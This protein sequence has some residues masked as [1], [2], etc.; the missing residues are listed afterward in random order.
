V[1]GVRLVVFAIVLL[2]ARVAHAEDDEAFGWSVDVPAGW[3]RDAAASEA[4]AKETRE[5]FFAGTPVAVRADLFRGPADS[6]LR[7]VTLQTAKVEDPAKVV[8]RWAEQPAARNAGD[9]WVAEFSRPGVHGTV[10]VAFFDGA[11]HF[12]HVICAAPPEHE[13]ACMRAIASVAITTAQEEEG[14]GWFYYIAIAGA[15]L[16]GIGLVG[17]RIELRRR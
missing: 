2:A 5:G 12:V 16:V 13:P 17:W 8:A 6:Q 9:R 1:I 3:T 14:S 7:V 15:L 4:T 11:H 10:Q